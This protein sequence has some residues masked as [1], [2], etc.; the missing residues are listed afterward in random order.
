MLGDHIELQRGVTGYETEIDENRAPFA[1]LRQVPGEAR[2]DSRVADATANAEHVYEL[3]GAHD[4][5]VERTD[6]NRFARARDEAADER[7]K[8]IF[9]DA[10]ILQVSIE[11]D[12]VVVAD[13]D[14]TRS[15]FANLGEFA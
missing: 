5:L 13:N 2:C 15:G 3:P 14:H 6:Q 7:F 11:D 4:A 9:G 12:I 8:E 1:C 10:D